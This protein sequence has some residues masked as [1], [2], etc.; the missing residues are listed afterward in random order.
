MITTS[1]TVCA[2]SE[3]TW[4][5]TRIVRPSRGERAE[6]V[7]EPADPLRVETVRRLVQHEHLGVAEERG[8]EAESLAHPE[9]VALHAPASRRAHVHE[10]EHLV[11]ARPRD[12]AGERKHPQVVATRPARMCVEG[13]EQHT[14][15]PDRV[16]ELADR[17]GRGRLSFP[18][19]GGR[20]REARASWSTCRRRSGRGIP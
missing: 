9:R 14:D 18:Q 12:T 7:T 11:D 6:E 3:R 13:L 10:R 20:G 5:E 17:A 2:T 15:A 4:L 8:R 19:S 1:S 16:L